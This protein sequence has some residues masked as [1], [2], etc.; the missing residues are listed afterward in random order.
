MATVR[1][2]GKTYSARWLQA[3]KSYAE[4]G[5]F[6][7]MKAAKLFGMEQEVAVKRGRGIR[8]GNLKMSLAEF[9]EHHW[10]H[11]L[12]KPNKQTKADYQNTINK[13][14]LPYFGKIPMSEIKQIDILKWQA[15][16]THEEKYFGKAL[17]RVTIQKYVNLLASIL[18]VAQNNDFIHHS[19]LKD[20]PRT[21]VKSQREISPLQMPQVDSLVSELADSLK[22]MV[23]I[24][25][26]TGLRPSE[27]LGLTLNEVDFEAK[28][29]HVRRQLSR[30]TDKVF[31]EKLKTPSSKR[32]IPLAPTL[33]ELINEHIAKFGLGPE[34]L[35]FKNRVG[36]VLRYKDAARSFRIAARKIGLPEREGLHV[37]RHTF[38][39]MLIQQGVNIKVIQ[40]LLGHSNISETLDT[41]G[42][43][44]PEDNSQAILTLE[45]LVANRD[46]LS[47]GKLKAADSYFA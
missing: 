44:F 24:P 14:I 15:K 40:S 5:G 2:R 37:L 3:D 26:Y 10:K 4:K 46:K 41:Y 31:E 25:F 33:E 1:K 34:N 18:K 30:Y 38:A 8:S 35:L 42:H 6:A 47:R 21:K 32:V 13:Y 16:L 39:S 20:V 11:T 28:V 7:T 19:P 9:I 23:W 45:T 29:I 22:L 12:T 36:G 17:S 27:T 43:L